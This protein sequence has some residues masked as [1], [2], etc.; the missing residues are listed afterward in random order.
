MRENIGLLLIVGFLSVL[1]AAHAQTPSPSPITAYDGTYAFVSGTKLNEITFATGTNRL[2]RC[3]NFPT[4]GPLVIASGHARY[5]GFGPVTYAGL[6]GTVGPHGDLLMRV[7]PSPVYRSN[8]PGVQM[9]TSARIDGGGTVR[10]R[11]V[12]NNCSYDFIWQKA[13]N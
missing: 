9:I 10:A 1:A 13:S 12:G 3:G 5:F 11:Q 4:V 6:E 8:G 7:A 2:I